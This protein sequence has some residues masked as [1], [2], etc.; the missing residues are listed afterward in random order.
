MVIMKIRTLG[1]GSAGAVR[2]RRMGMG[3][4]VQVLGEEDAEQVD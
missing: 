2:E 4:N 1:G 3:K